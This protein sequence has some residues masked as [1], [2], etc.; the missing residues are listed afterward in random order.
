MT[1]LAV[2]D[3]DGTLVDSQRRIIRAMELAFEKQGLTPPS[4]E[5]TRRSVG[6]AL[7]NAVAS[8]APKN[9]TAE[10]LALLTENFRDAYRSLLT[11]PSY[12]E[13]LYPGA[14]NA[15]DTIAEA[16][17]LLAI[18][19]G[20]GRRGLAHTLERHNLSGRF[21]VLKTADDGPSKPHPQ[22]LLDLM[23]EVGA[24]PGS[25][26]MLGDTSHDMAMAKAARVS[27]IGVAWGYHP[28][29]ELKL[30]G[31]VDV[32]YSYDQAPSTVIKVLEHRG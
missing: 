18:A 26:V 9:T 4:A 24:F 25:T 22:I 8:V 15:L 30:S 16:G 2:F 27:P 31:A 7:P 21:A 28:P 13:P 12:E 6:L 32:L 3:C 29:E 17:I 19:T 5:S 14:L 1:A 20:K 11:D 10:L 23:A